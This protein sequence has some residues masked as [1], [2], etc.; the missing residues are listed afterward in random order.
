MELPRAFPDE[1]LLGRLIRHLLLSGESSCSFCLRVLG[2]SRSSLHPF[3][4]AGISSIAK[5]SNE[6]AGKLLTC[7][8][9]APLFFFYLPQH[10]SSLKEDLLRG[11]GARAIRHSQLPSFCG[12][13][14]L[15]LKWC[16]LCVSED[17]IRV[18]VA[19]WHRAHQI[20]G[21]TSCWIHRVRLM[22][23]ELKTRQR[24]NEG[25]P[26]LDPRKAQAATAFENDVAQ[27]GA[28]LLFHLKR[29]QTATGDMAEKYRTRLY[30]L[31]Y[32]TPNGC[33][34]RKPLM[35][36]F[37][38]G[39]ATYPPQKSLFPR[40]NSDYHYI[41]TLLSD[42]ASCH[43]FRHLLFGAWLFRSA[44]DML[45]YPAPIAE[46]NSHEATNN[47]QR[48]DEKQGL[49]LLKQGFSLAA[50]YRMT[51]KSRCYLKR[52]AA[53][54]GVK[55]N[56]K[57][58]QLNEKLQQR[59]FRLAGLGVHRRRISQICSIGVGSVEQLIST[60]P[61][62]VKWRKLCHFESKRRRSRVQVLRYRQM[63]P[64][65]LRRE[66]KRDCSAA[67]FWLYHNDHEWLELMLPP[68]TQPRPCGKQRT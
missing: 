48:E 25:L 29:P 23:T 56:L 41:S 65:A 11:D 45:L 54:Y 18:G 2:S 20:P 27:F 61:D 31:G 15:H 8:T 3:L 32:I 5:L 28:E 57:P 53:V 37:T 16:P 6:D 14:A 4:T 68:A 12:G 44:E 62:L 9:L 33:V 43:P 22:S 19:Y 13:G 49:T 36:A 63:N 67:F 24:L 38:S 60:D 50:V 40:H 30:E 64:R 21:T 10:A 47:K 17:L 52:L 58:K 7:Q 42:G 59:I 34:R 39:L 66:I 46:S 35:R 51:G 26:P 1:L 55:L